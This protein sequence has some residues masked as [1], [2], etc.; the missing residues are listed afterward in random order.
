MAHKCL[1]YKGDI[2]GLF[3][4]INHNASPAF[5]LDSS[6]YHEEQGRY[7]FI[8]WAPR[9]ILRSRGRFIEYRENGQWHCWEGDPLT[10]LEGV[11]RKASKIMG[12]HDLPFPFCSGLVGYISYD[13][14]KNIEPLK[15]M[16]RDDLNMYDQYWGMYD[17]IVV[18]DSLSKKIWI[19][20][21]GKVKLRKMYEQISAGL[22]N[23]TMDKD[24]CLWMGDIRSNFISQDYL[25]A[26]ARI[27]EYICRG[28][29]YQANLSQRFR[30]EF[31]GSTLQYYEILRKINPSYFGA[32]LHF[33]NYDILS[34]SPERYIKIKGNYIETRPIK[35]TRPRGRDKREDHLLAGELQKSEKDRAEL[36]MI[37][38]LERNDLGKICQ[39]GTINVK[40][41]FKV[42]GYADVFHMDARVSGILKEDTGIDEVLRHTFPGGSITGA[43]KV[44]AQNIIEELEP[45]SRGVYT[46]A[47]GYIDFKGNCDLNIAIRTMVLTNGYGYYQAGGGI[48]ADSDPVLE[49]EETLAKSKALFNLQQ[50]VR[51]IADHQR[52][53]KREK[54]EY[55]F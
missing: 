45:T 55:N 40:D 10:A 47:I 51:H 11:R 34:M 39:P 4:S 33:D 2:W 23:E 7:S 32:Y 21:P 52:S 26:I 8:G 30:F 53:A 35:G 3:K 25:K 6:L 29:I 12:I 42:T 28:Y 20:G 17:G 54:A 19:V 9:A 36:L 38:D 15:S 48:V 14:G 46:G 43:P 27:K 37:V 13:M 5:F 31:R 18:A 41:L 1:H 49:Y 50:E 16:G 22:E 24:T 44:M